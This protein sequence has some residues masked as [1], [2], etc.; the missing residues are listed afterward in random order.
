MGIGGAALYSLALIVVRALPRL[1]SCTGR[2]LRRAGRAILDGTAQYGA[3]FYGMPHALDP[4]P[5]VSRFDQPP[6]DRTPRPELTE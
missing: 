3:S 5:L 1:Q 2:L 4:E 6:P